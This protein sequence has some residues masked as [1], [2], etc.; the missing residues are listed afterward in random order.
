MPG[1]V[2][3]FLMSVRPQDSRREC[4]CRVLP[5][6]TDAILTRT[7]KFHKMSDGT[8]ASN[9]TIFFVS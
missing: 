3:M 7:C 1:S 6:K 8:V 5:S 9:E 4:H 2:T